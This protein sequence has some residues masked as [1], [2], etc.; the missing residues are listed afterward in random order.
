MKQYLSLRT[1]DSGAQVT[2]IICTHGMCRMALTC[3][4]AG[5]AHVHFTVNAGNKAVNFQIIDAQSE[6]VC[7]ILFHKIEF[8]ECERLL[9]LGFRHYPRLQSY[10]C[11]RYN[12]RPTN[13]FTDKGSPST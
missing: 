8:L 7:L 10:F 4:A 1:N 3:E 2:F 5:Q 12:L 9:I 11:V 13:A 6:L